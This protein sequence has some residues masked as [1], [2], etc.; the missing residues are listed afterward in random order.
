MAIDPKKG[1]GLEA[2]DPSALQRPV[3]EAERLIELAEHFGEKE[4]RDSNAANAVIALRYLDQ[5]ANS[6]PDIR[7]QANTKAVAGYIYEHYLADFKRA[8]ACY[9]AA[10][11]IVPGDRT[12]I[13]SV[14]R[15]EREI[16][17]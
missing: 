3:D 1:R 14:E 12:L 9:R 13:D 16:R 4:P 15:L 2:T 5:A 7:M 17:R 10:L 11:K 6:F 8:V